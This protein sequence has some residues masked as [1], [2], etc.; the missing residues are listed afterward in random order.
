MLIFQQRTNMI[1]NFFPPPFSSSS[2]CH[3]LNVVSKEEGKWWKVDNFHVFLFKFKKFHQ[4]FLFITRQLLF[5]EYSLIIISFMFK[6][7]N[8]LLINGSGCDSVSMKK[9]S[10]ENLINNI[11][12]SFGSHFKFWIFCC[13]CC[14]RV[15]QEFF[16]ISEIYLNFI[17]KFTCS[18]FTVL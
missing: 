7:K 16:Y 12:T 15:S 8:F 18:Y 2:L 3:L 6:S 10:N 9:L 14:C 13:I 5:N 1:W 17:I 11:E 4:N